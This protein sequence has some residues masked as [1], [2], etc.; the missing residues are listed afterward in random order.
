ME[1]KFS[2][3]VKI[4]KYKLEDECER[5]ASMYFYWAEK[6]ANAKT[7]LDSRKD[8]LSLLSA[9]KDVAIRKEWDADKQGKMTEA[10]VKALVEQETQTAQ[11]KIRDAAAE[12]NTL[13]AAVASL[14]HRK[15]ELNNLVTLLVNGFYAAPNGGHR[16]GVNEQ[17]QRE[18]RGNLKKKRR[19]EDD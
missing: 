17:A 2:D 5:H 4:N 19:S 16:E 13:S 11:S 10:G 1:R 6:L 12:V 3:D 8:F 9:E 7:E 14:E 18:I 15:A